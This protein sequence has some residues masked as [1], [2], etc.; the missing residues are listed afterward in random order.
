VNI[1][2]LVAKD[3][4][5]NNKSIT[6][7]DAKKSLALHRKNGAKF[8]RFGNTI[9]IVF[10]VTDSA[11]F[12]HTINAD[13]I[14]EFLQNL[15]D[16]FHAIKDK[17]YAITYFTDERLK[18]VYSRYGDEVVG[19]DDQSLGTHKGITKLQRWKHGLG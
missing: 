16:F 11:V 18:S 6:V 7:E 1:G 13:S 14:K 10:R 4:K 5:R 15:R 12:Y 19:S 3:I 9:F 8:Y 17:E 2:E